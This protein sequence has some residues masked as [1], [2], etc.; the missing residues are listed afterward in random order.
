MKK[1]IVCCIFLACCN[2]FAQVLP[3]AVNGIKNQT[4]TLSTSSPP[5]AQ[6]LWYGPV[7]FTSQTSVSIPAT[8][9]G[10]ATNNLIV[11]CTNGVAECGQTNVDSSGNITVTFLSNSTGSIWVA[12]GLSYSQSF[13]SQTSITIAATS[14]QASIAY[15]AC[16]DNSGNQ[17]GAGQLTYTTFD[18]GIGGGQNAVYTLVLGATAQTGRCV[19]L[20]APGK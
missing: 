6:I 16:Y 18:T 8:T 4:I 2:L 17:F 15:T 7:N 1:A 3:V 13:T 19:F 11:I 9:H 14:L 5:L 20:L 12:S 10:F